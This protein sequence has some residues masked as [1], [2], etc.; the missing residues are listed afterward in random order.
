M[1]SVTM[2][3]TKSILRPTVAQGRD[4]GMAMTL[5]LLLLTVTFDR[6]GLV[7][8]AIVVLIL[9]MTVPGVFRPVAVVWF[10]LAHVLGAVM[11]RVLLSMVFVLLVVPVG[12]F[13]RMT[14]RDRLQRREFRAGSDSV[15]AVRDHLYGPRDLEKPY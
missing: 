13:Q 6:S 14:G 7:V 4:T 3:A 8:P 15:F 2:T 9:S 11:S 10:G 5:L 12:L 1:V